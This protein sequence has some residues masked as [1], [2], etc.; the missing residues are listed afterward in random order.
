MPR[1]MSLIHLDEQAAAGFE[2]DPDFERD[3]GIAE[4][5]LGRAGR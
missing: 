5:L 2:P 4:E 1:F 3:V